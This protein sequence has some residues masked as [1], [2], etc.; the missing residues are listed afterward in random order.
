M[1]A[2]YPECRPAGFG[3]QV[4]GF[5]CQPANDCFQKR[6]Y[7]QV[8]GER[9]LEPGPL[10]YP[11][12]LSAGSFLGHVPGAETVKEPAAPLFWVGA[13]CECEEPS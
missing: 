6:S 2:G 10:L 5:R 12:E 3:C 4:L 7:Q 9:V 8:S 1:S 11:R 13:G